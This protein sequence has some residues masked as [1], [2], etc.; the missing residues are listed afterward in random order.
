M[1]REDLGKNETAVNNRDAT[2]EASGQVF[3]NNKT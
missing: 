2:S 1:K 3:N